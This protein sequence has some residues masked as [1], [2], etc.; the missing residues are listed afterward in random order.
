MPYHCYYELMLNVLT[1]R[2]RRNILEI[3]IDTGSTI[4]VICGGLITRKLPF[5]FTG[6]D[7][8]VQQS[9]TSMVSDYKTLMTDQQQIDLIEQNS[10]T[11]LLTQNQQYDLILLDGDHNFF[12]VQQELN[13]LDKLVV[14]DGAIFVDDYYGKWSDRDL[15]YAERPGYE[16]TAATPRVDTEFHGVKPA[17]DEFVNSHNEWRIMMPQHS[18]SIILVKDRTNK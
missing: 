1:N 11:W 8:K 3:G 5:S 4:R 9:V 7:I 13:Q 16:L 12:T 6:V 2:E 18:E 10:L 17:V 15:F 14:D